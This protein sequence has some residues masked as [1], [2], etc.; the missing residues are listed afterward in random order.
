MWGL[1]KILEYG[2]FGLIGE[3][4]EDEDGREGYSTKESKALY[5]DAGQE[6]IPEES[7]KSPRYPFE[8]RQ[9]IPQ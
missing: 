5:Y 2:M 7:S 8:Y 4:R 3:I 1:T 6:R 9:E